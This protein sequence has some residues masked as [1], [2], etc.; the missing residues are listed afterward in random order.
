MI[1][2][3]Q[4]VS[5][6]VTVKETDLFIRADKNLEQV[7]RDIVLKYRGYIEAYIKENPRFAQ[8][9]DPWHINGPAP[10]IIKDMARAGEIAGVGP[11]ASVAGAIAE[12]VGKDMLSHTDEII[13]ENG[14]DVFINTKQPL[15]V[16]IYAGE[17]PL[18]LRIGVHLEAKED[19]ISVCTS[20]GRIGHSLSLG[21]AHAVCVVAQS[22]ALA[23]AAATAIA[24]RVR[25]KSDIRRA[26]EFGQSI[27]GAIGLVVIVD[28]ATGMW[29]DLNVVPLDLKKG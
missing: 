23:D 8:T 19:P 26:I 3:A 6:R 18:S 21:R 15:T 25:S 5:F 13:V 4:L 29:G 14:G 24:N 1:Q 12:Y 16:G 11:M 9:L 17:S 7:T 27:N 2:G 28:D 10:I 20:S 22:C